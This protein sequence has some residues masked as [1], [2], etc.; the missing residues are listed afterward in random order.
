MRA[1][2]NGVGEI[3]QLERHLG[4]GRRAQQ[5]AQRDT[6][7]VHPLEARQHQRQLRV[8]G[9]GRTPAQR[10]IHLFVREHAIEALLIERPVDQLGMAHHGVGE[11]MAVGEQ[12]QHGVQ[13]SAGPKDR[14]GGMA[15]LDQVTLQVVQR[16]VGVGHLAKETAQFGAAARGQHRAQSFDVFR[17]AAAVLELDV[18]GAVGSVHPLICRIAHRTRTTPLGPAQPRTATRAGRSARPGDD[19]MAGADRNPAPRAIRAP[20]ADRRLAGPP[21]RHRW[22]TL[23]DDLEA[24]VPLTP[25]GWPKLFPNRD[26]IAALSRGVRIAWGQCP[27]PTNSALLHWDGTSLVPSFVQE[28]GCIG[29]S[30]VPERPV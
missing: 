20:A 23:S 21:R 1:V 18:L 15:G 30:G 3:G 17:G 2:E 10:R 22:G 26:R 19:A 28:T 4:K 9:N 11:E 29:H 24:Q 14:F 27:E 13:P 7:Q 6:N 12:R 25:F 8:F 5:I 16:G